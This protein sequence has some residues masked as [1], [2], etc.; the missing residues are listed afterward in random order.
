MNLTFRTN[1]NKMTYENYL[2]QPKPMLEW[3]IIEKL[4]KNPNL[5]KAIDRIL[6]HPIVQENFFTS[7][8]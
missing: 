1:F 8:K 3:R 5:A 7:I 4:A 6:S 2:K